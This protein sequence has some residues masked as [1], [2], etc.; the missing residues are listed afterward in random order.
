VQVAEVVSGLG[1]HH[2][3][4]FKSRFE[5]G[6]AFE[7]SNGYIP[8]PF[9]PDPNYQVFRFPGVSPT[10]GLYRLHR[11]RKERFLPT[12]RPILADSEGEIAAFIERA[13][14]AHQRHA[15]SGHYKLSPSG[16]HYVYTLGG[17]IRHAWLEAWPIKRF[18][19]TR[20]Y[21]R[22]QKMARELGFRINPKGGRLE[23]T[24]PARVEE[25]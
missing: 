15:H 7:T 1:K 18:R 6:F 11:K 24:A 14:I 5:N 25:N 12:H 10:G 9:K 13:E 19:T 21:A 16:E 22:A 8:S 3:I 4:V 23:E 2:L 20:I 17:A